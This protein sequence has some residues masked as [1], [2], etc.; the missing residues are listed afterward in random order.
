MAAKDQL[1]AAQSAT[2]G[3]LQAVQ[4]TIAEEA[5][6]L[7]RQN[8]SL[9]MDAERTRRCHEQVSFFQWNKSE[10]FLLNFP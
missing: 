9:S 10:F 4:A 8:A 3:E 5:G 2:I 7:K 6:R 1:I